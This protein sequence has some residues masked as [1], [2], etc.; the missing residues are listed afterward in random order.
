[1]VGRFWVIRICCSCWQSPDSLTSLPELPTTLQI[2]SLLTSSLHPHFLIFLLLDKW[3]DW[4]RLLDCS[5]HHPFLGFDLKIKAVYI[6]VFGQS[7]AKKWKKKS[8]L[9]SP[10]QKK[11]Y[12]F[13]W[14]LAILP[15]RWSWIPGEG[16]F[17]NEKFGCSPETD[18]LST[19]PR[20]FVA[21]ILVKIL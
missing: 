18:H 14:W 4:W 10:P 9:S 5:S 19:L 15:L 21:F 3:K 16:G 1:M 7:A 17:A 8:P 12:I 13:D 11:I 6:Q 2:P 20:P